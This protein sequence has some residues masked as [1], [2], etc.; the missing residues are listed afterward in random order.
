MPETQI[1]SV[2]SETIDR[3]ETRAKHARRRVKW[4]A[5][6]LFTGIYAVAAGIVIWQSRYPDLPRSVGFI[7]PWGESRSRLE[8][9]FARHVIR[10]KEQLAGPA[11]NLKGV[12]SAEVKGFV[13]PA[14][15][16][17]SRLNQELKVAL[18]DL[19]RAVRIVDA[20]KQDAEPHSTI[21]PI[22]STVVFSLGAVTFLVLLIQIAVM[23]MRYYTRLAELYDAQADALRASGGDPKL[24][25]G[26]LEHFSPNSIEIGKSPTTLYEKA[27]DTIKEVARKEKH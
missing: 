7:G 9:P 27:L 12:A 11:P 4:V 14:G 17:A 24:A 15:Q 5:M 23:F 20:S 13:P 19:E 8:A 16:E 25:Y 18:D 3:L 6:I 2:F 10:I 22:I 21:G 1:P 26:F